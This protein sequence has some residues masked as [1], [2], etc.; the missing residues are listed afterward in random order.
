MEIRRKGEC[1]GPAFSQLGGKKETGI[2]SLFDQSVRSRQFKRSFLH[3]TDTQLRR[4]W[5]GSVKAAL[6]IVL[7]DTGGTLW[8]TIK[9]PSP[10]FPRVLEAG[11]KVEQKN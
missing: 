7:T 1:L 2:K 3:S 8:K 11:W 5:T 9:V 10:S 6:D 4:A